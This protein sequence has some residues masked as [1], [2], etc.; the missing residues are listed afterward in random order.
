MAITFRPLPRDPQQDKRT[1]RFMQLLAKDINAIVN[2][3][4]LP[5]PANVA[6]TDNANNFTVKQ[7]IDAYYGDIDTNADGATVTFNMNSSNKHIV[8]L[9]GNR[10]LAVSNVDNG[11]VFMVILQ[12]D[13]GGNRTV[14]WWSGIRWS[15]G[16]VPTLTTTGGKIDVF[17][18]IQLTPGVYL[19]FT[20]GLN[21]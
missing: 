12:Q 5:L 19:G 21:F 8:T 7:K 2:G 10:T 17:N 6:F 3:A 11:Q 13:G 9:G 4:S 15:G 16:T 1:R 20:T 14:T 18:F